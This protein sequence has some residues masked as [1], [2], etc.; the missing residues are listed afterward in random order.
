MRLEQVLRSDEFRVQCTIFLI[1]RRETFTYTA[2]SDLHASAMRRAVARSLACVARLGPSRG[3]SDGG[4]GE[5]CLAAAGT[6]VSFIFPSF[7]ATL[8]SAGVCLSRWAAPRGSRELT[9]QVSSSSPVTSAS[10]APVL[11][12][13]GRPPSSPDDGIALLSRYMRELERRGANDLVGFEPGPPL[14][15]HAMTET[16]RAAVRPTQTSPCV[17]HKVA[18]DAVLRGVCPGCWSLSWACWCSE[19][20]PLRLPGCLRLHFFVHPSEY[21]RCTNTVRVIVRG[22][23]KARAEQAAADLSSSSS[24]SSNNASGTFAPPT[25]GEASMLLFGVAAHE[26][27]LQGILAGNPGRVCILYPSPDSVDARSY[28]S[29]SPSLRQFVARMPSEGDGARA[30][31]PTPAAMPAGV[32]SSAPPRP[33]QP[34]ELQH[35]DVI[36]LDG[37]WSQARNLNHQIS[38]F[39]AQRGVPAPQCL[40]IDPETVVPAGKSLFHP[41][42]QQ[43][44]RD[45]CCTLEATA[46]LLA[47]LRD[48]G[49]AVEPML[50][51]LRRLVDYTGLQGSLSD[52]QV[53]GTVQPARLAELL[54]NVRRHE[55]GPGSRKVRES[56]LK[57]VL[58]AP[59]A[60]SLRSFANRLQFS[61]SVP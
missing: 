2:C 57:S 14:D 7:D 33:E 46:A 16:E 60:G 53:Y 44:Q 45:R 40:R 51:N 27:R 1:T 28:L 10:P 17:I 43:S 35:L 30:P 13:A 56:A 5:G 24:P 58:P 32:S 42:R 37:T 22:V 23:T 38:K 61:A 50:A 49:Q 34:E 26:A 25:L 6:S 9:T 21:L 36:V 12:V 18:V 55:R 29:A 15:F 4:V 59:S 54:R 31:A 39:C 48:G 11:A 3:E 41:V 47:L 19:H 8:G 52:P 20:L